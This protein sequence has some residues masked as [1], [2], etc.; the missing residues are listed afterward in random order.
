MTT[1]EIRGW[2]DGFLGLTAWEAHARA[3]LKRRLRRGMK[4]S[5]AE[6]RRLAR[7]ISN[8]ELVC[9]YEVFDE[10]VL[11]IMQI[12]ETIGAEMFVSLVHSDT[13]K[14]LRKAPKRGVRPPT[15]SVV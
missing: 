7:Q 15:I 9:L 14:L 1:I 5:P 6:I 4:A 3:E 8:R 2:K 10:A 11:G 13:R 12:L